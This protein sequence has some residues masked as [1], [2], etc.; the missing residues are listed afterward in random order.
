MSFSEAIASRKQPVERPLSEKQSPILSFPNPPDENLPITLGYTLILHCRD[1]NVRP[2]RS[3]RRRH[4]HAAAHTCIRATPDPG[5]EIDRTNRLPVMYFECT[6]TEADDPAARQERRPS[7]VVCVFV[8][9]CARGTVSSGLRA[10]FRER[11][12]REP[13]LWNLILGVGD[14]D[15]FIYL[16]CR[17]EKEREECWVRCCNGVRLG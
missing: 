1:T 3:A 17:A 6:V 9:I 4:F 14:D 16:G 12:R 8:Y 15:A 5:I 13:A 2:Y 7:R 10:R 11:R